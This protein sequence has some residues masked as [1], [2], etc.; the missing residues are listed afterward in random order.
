MVA[1]APWPWMLKLPFSILLGV[2][3][4]RL[5]IIGHDAAH[6]SL[7]GSQLLNAVVARLAFLPSLHPC[8]LWQVG[9]NRVHHSFTNLKGLDFIWIPFSPKEYTKLPRWRRNLEHFYRSVFGFWAYYLVEIWWKYLSFSGIRITQKGRWRYVIDIALVL[10]FL[11][12][13][14]ITVLSARAT[15]GPHHAL[16][17]LR[18]IALAVVVPFVV[19]NWLMA[20]IIYNHHTHASVRFFKKRSEWCF[21]EGQVKGTVHVMFPRTVGMLLNEIM[22]HTVHHVDVN[23]PYYRLAAAQRFLQQHLR[24]DL[25]VEKWSLQSF[26]RTVHR[27]QVYDYDRHRWMTFSE[28]LAAST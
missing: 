13:Q 22:E 16:L 24:N 2:L 19:W 28:A 26:A 25:V 7:T 1:R 12:V 4:T 5:F 23:I 9:H 11:G 27:C 14:V 3:I 20:F 8:S 6:G 10:G 17:A 18:D 15:N 21:Y